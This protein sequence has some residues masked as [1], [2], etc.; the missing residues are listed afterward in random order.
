MLRSIVPIKLTRLLK[1]VFYQ[2][3][4]G[5]RIERGAVVSCSGLGKHC[6]IGE[7]TVV[8]KSHL[9]DLSYVAQS[10]FISRSI[11]GKYC[12]IGDNVR[13]GLGVHPTSKFVSTHPSFYSPRAHVS[14]TDELLFEEHIFINAGKD[15][16]VEIGSDV[17]IGSSSII[18]DGVKIGHGAIVGA[19]AV[20]TKNVE[21]YSIVGG[22]P[23]KVIKYRF[24]PDIIDSLLSI[25]WWDEDV[26]WVIDNSDKFSDISSFISDFNN[27]K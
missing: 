15:I 3:K 10:S 2:V 21:P 23:A 8:F 27:A 24:S 9:D 7:N 14:F 22:V 13:I 18:M 16:C 17:W 11:I 20:V 25:S 5:A 19:G 4:Y 26:N 12:S 1:R 6:Y